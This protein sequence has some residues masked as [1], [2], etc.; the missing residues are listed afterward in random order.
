M[1]SSAFR[2]TGCEN[3][4]TSGV[5]DHRVRT[6]VRWKSRTYGRTHT[7]THTH[8]AMVKLAMVLLGEKKMFCVSEV[9]DKIIKLIGN[10]GPEP[11]KVW[12][13]SSFAVAIIKPEDLQ[14][15][16]T[17]AICTVY[18]TSFTTILS[19]TPK[20]VFGNFFCSIHE[21]THRYYL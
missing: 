15:I 16:H 1:E 21:I 7:H 3:D 2:K 14:V 11:F 5:P 19:I 20:A 13:G 4:R 9:M 8:T 10:Y 6:S 17:R 18:I 12:L